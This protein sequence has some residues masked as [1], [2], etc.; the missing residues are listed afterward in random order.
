MPNIQLQFRR[1]TAAEWASANP[2]LAAGEM[3]IETDT[4]KFK[5]GDGTTLWN[6]LA[7]GGIQ[8]PTGN[9]GPT[10]MTGPTGPQGVSGVSGGLV[11]ILDTAG[12]AAPQTGTLEL[13]PNTG[14]Q[15]TITSGSQTNTNDVLLGTFVSPVGA[16]STTLIAGGFWEFTTHA[17]ASALGVSYYADIYYVDADGSSN[18]V[19]IAT[20]AGASDAIGILEGQWPHSIYVPTTNLPDSTKRIRVRLYGNFVGTGVSATLYFR[21]Q[22]Q[23]YVHTTILQ[24]LPTGPT[25][26][27]GPT[28]P[29]GDTGP[30]GATSTVTGPTGP[31]GTNGT[32]GVDGDTGP[33]GP[34]GTSGQTRLVV[35][36]VT[37][38]S[39]TLS[40]AN[41]NQF[42]YLTNSGFNALTLPATTATVDGGSFWTLRNA[43]SSSLSMTLTNTLSLTSPLVVPPSNSQTLTVS[44]TASNTILLM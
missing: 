33:T 7:Y 4:N 28:G 5:L 24:S 15:T 19:L 44:A 35:T 18:P 25:G 14:T 34:T 2:T 40:S 3:G 8:G 37:G 17:I 1:G 21:A 23:A 22:T 29:T 38:T 6:A 36:E 32:I 13:S 26:N 42:L 10:G 12:G 41:Y 16:I 20:G 9:T 43:T 30:T 39:A 31:Q 27:T 11:L